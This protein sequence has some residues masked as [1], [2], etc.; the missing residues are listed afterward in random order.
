MEKDLDA[1]VSESKGETWEKG[2]ETAELSN[3]GKS[4]WFNLKDAAIL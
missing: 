4:A 3:G 1:V 2:L